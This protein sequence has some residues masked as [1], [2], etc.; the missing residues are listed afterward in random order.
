VFVCLH[1]NDQYVVR[2]IF[3]AEKSWGSDIKIGD[4]IKNLPVR[5]DPLD[6]GVLVTRESYQWAVNGPLAQ[7]AIPF[8]RKGRL[9]FGAMSLREVAGYY[10]QHAQQ[11]QKP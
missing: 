4:A 8:D 7:G 9:F 6:V 11:T 1:E 2:K 3:K 5:N 10:D